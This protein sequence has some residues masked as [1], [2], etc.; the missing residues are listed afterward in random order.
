M[1]GR[2]WLVVLIVVA[3]IAVSGVIFRTATYRESLTLP[4]RVVFEV[5]AL[6]QRWANGLVTAVR[7][8]VERL[9]ALR[10]ALEENERLRRELDA[11]RAERDRLLEAGRQN[12][13]LRALLDLTAGRTEQVAVAEVIARSPSNW[14]GSITVDKGRIHGVEP[15]MAV[16]AAEGAVGK[17]RHVTRTTAEVLLITDSR[18]S[19]GGRVRDSGYLVLVEGTGDPTEAKATVRLL[20][21]EGELRP[22]DVVVASELSWAFPKGLPIGVVE[23]VHTRE[24]GLTPYGILRPFVDLGRLEWV[25]ILKAEAIDAPWWEEEP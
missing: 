5:M 12:E 18:S 23:E 11:L 10:T 6:L 21:W 8:G 14:L 25:I 1:K 9:A 2:G 19:I 3:L 17:V 15:G 22:G 16:V 7:S 24:P 20:E 4:E 13:Q